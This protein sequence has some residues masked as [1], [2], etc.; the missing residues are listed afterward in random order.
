[1]NEIWTKGN[2][3]GSGQHELFFS[4]RPDEL[5]LAQAICAPCEVRLQ[6]LQTALREELDWGVWGGVIFWDGKPLHRK[7]TRGRPRRSD[8]EL[9]VEASRQEL[10]ELVKSA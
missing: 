5:A 8:G 3:V 6:C 10:L 2:C 1:M 9:P 7:R 4:D